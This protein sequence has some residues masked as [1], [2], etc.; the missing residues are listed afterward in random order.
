MAWEVD[1]VVTPVLD[2]YKEIKGTLVLT[3]G[4]P[5]CSVTMIL[6]FKF[7]MLQLVFK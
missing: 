5:L 7:I 3:I 4:C 6:P 2:C 1:G